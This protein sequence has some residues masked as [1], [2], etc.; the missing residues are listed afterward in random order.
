MEPFKTT[1]FIKRLIPAVT[2]WAVGKALETPRVKQK[3]AMIDS[4]V[5]RTHRNVVRNAKRNRGWL[6]AGAAVML[7]GAGLMAKSTRPK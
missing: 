7:I 6:A 4:T 2:V 5:H 3:V 1:T